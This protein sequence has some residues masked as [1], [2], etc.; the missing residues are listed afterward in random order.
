MCKSLARNGSRQSDL[1][2]DKWPKDLGVHRSAGLLPVVCSTRIERAVL[3]MGESEPR[4]AG[5]IRAASSGPKAGNCA[6]AERRHRPDHTAHAR[7]WKL[8]ACAEARPWGD[9]AT[10]THKLQRR[11]RW[12]PG[13]VPMPPSIAAHLVKELNRVC[14][15]VP[16]RPPEV[17]AS[18]IHTKPSTK[19]AMPYITTGGWRNQY[20]KQHLQFIYAIY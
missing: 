20:T 6:C 16:W 4:A 10:A 5:L 2:H 11:G 7:Q 12:E 15:A 17:M 18:L 14:G 1:P 19:S 3:Y 8:R 13:R 9:E